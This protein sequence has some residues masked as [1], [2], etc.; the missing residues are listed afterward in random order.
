MIFVAVPSGWNA[1]ET[2]PGT[3]DRI[4]FWIYFPNAPRAG[5]DWLEARNVSVRGSGD[6][7]GRVV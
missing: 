2:L 4:L 6:E 3:S 5:L 7:V 1:A